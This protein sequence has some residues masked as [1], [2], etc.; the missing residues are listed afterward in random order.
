MIIAIEEAKEEGDST[1]SARYGIPCT[2]TYNR[3]RSKARTV[4]TY[5]F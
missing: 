4:S 2:D 5:I 3:A 1:V